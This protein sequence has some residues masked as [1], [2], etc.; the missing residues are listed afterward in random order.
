M[1]KTLLG[2]FVL[3]FALFGAGMFVLEV[4]ATENDS[5]NEALQAIERLTRQEERIERKQERFCERVER[6]N[7]QYDIDYPYPDYCKNG[8]DGSPS[9]AVSEGPFHLAVTD[10]TVSNTS[11]TVGEEV[12]MQVTVENTGEAGTGELLIE[13]EEENENL[14]HDDYQEHLAFN[15]GEKRM[16]SFLWTPTIAGLRYVDAGA[17]SKTWGKLFDWAW[18]GASFTVLEDTGSLPDPDP[19]PDPEPEPEPAPE[20]NPDPAPDQTPDPA[21]DPTPDPEPEPEPMSDVVINEIAWMG[22]NVSSNDEWIELYNRGDAAQ[23]LT[24]WSVV[25]TDGTPAIELTGTV[26]AGGYYLLERQ[27]DDSVPGETADLVYPFGNSL[28]N[29]GEVLELRNGASA[30]VDTVNG[31]DSWAIGGDNSSKETVQRTSDNLWFTAE[32]TP[33][34][35]NVIDPS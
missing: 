24:G 1:Q 32:G 3:L 16:F 6:M 33:K 25:A 19:D 29:S 34:A 11:P 26:P 31:S 22:S 35:E 28:G 2:T 18:H 14:L 27:D 9:C 8:G 13:V 7:E 30:V 4:E 17:F 21:P 10:I 12:E 20:P 5:G 15:A 23:D